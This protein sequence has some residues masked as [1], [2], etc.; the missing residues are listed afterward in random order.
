MIRA[1]SATGGVITSA[2]ILL[3]AVFAVLGVLPL[4]TLTQIGIIV[5]IGVLL[6]TL[7]VRTVLVPALAFMAGENFW[8]PSRVRMPAHAATPSAEKEPVSVEA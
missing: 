2:G 8:W 7:I 5:C 4:I 1:L 6:D 3:A